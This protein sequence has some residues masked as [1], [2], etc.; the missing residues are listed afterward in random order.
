MRTFN[1]YIF[2]RT[3]ALSYLLKKARISLLIIR[4]HLYIMNR[5]F[6]DGVGETLS[7]S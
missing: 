5:L 3:F 7:I 2:S 1:I 4:K 6:F